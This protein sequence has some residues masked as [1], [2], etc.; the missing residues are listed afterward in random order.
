MNYYDNLIT[1]DIF[2]SLCYQFEMFPLG[3]AKV[4]ADLSSIREIIGRVALRWTS[5]PPKREGESR[6]MLQKPG[7]GPV[8]WDKLYLYTLTVFHVYARL[9][10][11]GLLFCGN[12]IK[13]VMK[14]L[15]SIKPLQ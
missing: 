9:K 2:S 1:I 6:L 12:F 5:I 7:Q 11:V 3:K 13:L 8:M 10:V 15:F 14:L 4:K